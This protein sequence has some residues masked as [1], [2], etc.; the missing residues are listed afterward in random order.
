M[1]WS[2][3]S[4]ERLR[5]YLHANRYELAGVLAGS[6]ALHAACWLFVGKVL[7]HGVALSVGGMVAE[8]LQS[9]LSACMLYVAMDRMALIPLNINATRLRFFVL[10]GIRGLVALMYLAIVELP[11]SLLMWHGSVEFVLQT[12]FIHLSLSLVILLYITER[13][14]LM[15][16]MEKERALVD[17]MLM[18]TE[19]QLRL[20]RSQ[21]N[22]HFLFNSLASLQGIIHTRPDQA[23]AF[24]VRLSKVYRFIL[25][26]AE[27]DV[28]SLAEASDFADLYL[29]LLCDSSP[30]CFVATNN[31]PEGIA[32]DIVPMAMQIAIENAVKHNKHTRREPLHIDMYVERGCVCVRNNYN[33]ASTMEDS[34]RVGLGNL[35]QQYQLLGNMEVA[36][37]I[38]DGDF[39]VRFPIIPQP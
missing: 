19:L 32:G 7:A 27:K 4:S 11:L 3:H 9:I 35:R 36:V 37:E 38:A 5:A 2:H 20:T 13:T 30:E 1:I 22:P 26:N 10:G 31:I 21:L 25:R 33:P 28:I 18:Q 15:L 16:I 23:E 39:I 17:A 8:L 14:Y 29:H 34:T 6:L 24:L 12:L